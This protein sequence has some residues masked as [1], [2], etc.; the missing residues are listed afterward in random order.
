V[1]WVI[2]NVVRV[3]LEKTQLMRSVRNLQKFCVSKETADFTRRET[4]EGEVR[5]KFFSGDGWGKVCLGQID[6]SHNNLNVR[7]GRALKPFRLVAYSV[8]G[9][10]SARRALSRNPRKFLHIDLSMYREQQL[11][12]Q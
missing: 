9:A 11:S 7:N 12:D 8:G 10:D 6:V 5:I 2:E 4:E 1:D 3:V